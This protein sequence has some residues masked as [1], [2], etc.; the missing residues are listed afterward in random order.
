ME[1]VYLESTIFSYLVSRPSRD[2]IVAARISENSP[3]AKA[4]NSPK[5]ALQKNCDQPSKFEDPIVEEVRAARH[6]LAAR[7]DNDLHQIANDL[8]SRQTQLGKRLRT[9]AG[10][11]KPAHAV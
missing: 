1:S 4:M 2:I 5:S 11:E 9:A 7:L 10:M 8:M 6:A 3:K